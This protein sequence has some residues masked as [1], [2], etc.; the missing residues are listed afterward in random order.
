[1][2][3]QVVRS[4]L[5]FVRR[6]SLW[7]ALVVPCRNVVIGED[8]ILWVARSNVGA[9]ITF[10]SFCDHLAFSRV[11]HPVFGP[12]RMSWTHLGIVVVV[13]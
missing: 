5:T 1:M 7:E 4:N 11:G 8:G 10:K 13:P 6:F 9:I 12:P 2:W 3:C